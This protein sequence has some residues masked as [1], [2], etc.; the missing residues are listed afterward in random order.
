LVNLALPIG[1]A[2]LLGLIVAGFT[3]LPDRTKAPW[4]LMAIGTALNIFGDSSSFLQGSFGSTRI[5]M[6]LNA[7][8]WPMAIV[9][10][11][12]VVWLRLKPASPVELERPTNIALPT[13]AA[14]ALSRS[15]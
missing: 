10:M 6:D 14:A 8:A 7:I 9:L 12:M 1:D 3:I 15:S 4:M 13:C 5:G 2:L 11:S